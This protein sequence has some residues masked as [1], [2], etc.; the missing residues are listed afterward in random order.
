MPCLVE[1][2]V[3]CP[4]F[5]FALLSLYMPCTLLLP[6]LSTLS[7]FT[8]FVCSNAMCLTF[9]FFPCLGTGIALTLVKTF[10][11]KSTNLLCLNAYSC[12]SIRIR[13]SCNFTFFNGRND[14]SKYIKIALCQL[15]SYNLLR[16]YIAFIGTLMEIMQVTLNK[17]HM[18]L[19]NDI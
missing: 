7:L 4:L 3:V 2:F 10:R 6:A 11:K 14:V 12:T 5:L 17:G 9:Q 8:D 13:K 15:L 16:Y 18:F 19:K 1:A